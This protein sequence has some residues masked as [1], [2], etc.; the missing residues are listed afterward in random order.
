MNQLVPN[1]SIKIA[2]DTNVYASRSFFNMFQN[3]T[4]VQ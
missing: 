1:I 3:Y 4:R 2:K